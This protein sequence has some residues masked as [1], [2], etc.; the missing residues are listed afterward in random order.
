MKQFFDKRGNP[1]DI[2]DHVM[3]GVKSNGMSEIGKI[4]IGPVVDITGVGV[5]LEGHSSRVKVAHRMVK[6]SKD[7]Y[8]KWKSYQ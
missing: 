5:L 2:G 8:E 1:I 4:H 6:V 3:I 7:F